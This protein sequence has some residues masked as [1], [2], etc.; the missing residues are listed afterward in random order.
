MIL[1]LTHHIHNLG[2]VL[3]TTSPILDNH[4]LCQDPDLHLEQLSSCPG[5]AEHIPSFFP[6]ELSL[7]LFYHIAN[8]KL[9][10][11]LVI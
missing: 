9:D 10:F 7:N 11:I 1:L 5:G 2:Q 3:K 8:S 6:K 4:T